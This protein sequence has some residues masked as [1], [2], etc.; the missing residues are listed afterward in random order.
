M[1]LMKMAARNLWRNKRR[2]LI[3]L[4]AMSFALFIMIFYTGFLDGYLAEFEHNAIALNLAKI[5]IHHPEYRDD[6][7]IYN[8]IENTSEIIQRLEADGF[9]VSPRYI[10][11]GL[12]AA[13]DQSAGVII[14]GID[15]AREAGVTDLHK[16]V[17]RGRWLT[18][19][20]GESGTRGV[21]IGRKLARTLNAGLGDELVIVSQAADGSIANDLFYVR[22]IFKTVSE[23]VDRSGFMITDGSFKSLMSFDD[24]A[25]EI[26]I[27]PPEDMPLDKAVA[28]ASADAP[29]METLS[30]REL[31]PDVAQMLDASNVSMILLYIIA[32]AAIALVTLNAMLMAVFERIREFGIMKAVGVTPGQ[33]WWIINLEALILTLLA[34]VAGTVT[35]LPVTLYYAAHGVDLSALSQGT[36]FA[37]IAMDSNINPVVSSRTVINPALFMAVMVWLAVIYPGVKAAVIRPIKAIYH[38]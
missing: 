30:W 14:R 22:G 31:A 3:T 26:A 34:I 13:G 20:D 21:M 24:G 23:A 27:M 15:P 5:Q 33:V 38:R 16:H 9:R 35:G 25:H 18:E 1:L 7:S 8:A 36:A 12:A 29:G 6:S 19:K 28:E 37:G 32:Y 10:S 4:G 17:A 2:T 11:Y